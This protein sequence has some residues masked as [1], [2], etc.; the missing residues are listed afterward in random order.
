MKDEATRRRFVRRS[1]SGMPPL[2]LDDTAEPDECDL[3]K[4]LLFGSFFYTA[5][6][7][8]TY[9]LAVVKT[10]MQASAVQMSSRDAV[11]DLLRT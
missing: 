3:P 7:V 2:L 4:L 6:N 10:R 8:V 9:P 11:R 1:M 5:L